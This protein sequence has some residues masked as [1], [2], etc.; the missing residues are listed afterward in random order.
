MNPTPSR[1]PF[2]CPSS[3]IPLR[4]SRRAAQGSTSLYLANLSKMQCRIWLRTSLTSTKCSTAFLPKNWPKVRQGNWPRLRASLETIR[5]ADPTAREKDCPQTRSFYQSR[6][7]T[8]S[9]RHQV[10][11]SCRRH[12]RHS[13]REQR[14]ESRLHSATDRCDNAP[15]SGSRQLS[16]GERRILRVVEHDDHDAS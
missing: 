3:S 4:I 6:E 12:L 7:K 14:A 2:R 10:C 8:R 15:S 13:T 5:D 1:I 9:C 16:D 11:W